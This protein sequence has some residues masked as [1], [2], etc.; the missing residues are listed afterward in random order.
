VNRLSVHRCKAWL[1]QRA[2][3][4][5][6]RCLADLRRQASAASTGGVRL[7]VDASDYTIDGVRQPGFYDVRILDGSGTFRSAAGPMSYFSAGG[8]IRRN[9]AR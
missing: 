5:D 8:Y 2:P 6:H 4:W 7:E 1:R 3:W 9:S